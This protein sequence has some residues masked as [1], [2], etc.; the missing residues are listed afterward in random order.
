VSE[1][2][3]DAVGIPHVPRTNSLAGG[4]E[5]ASDDDDGFA[6]EDRARLRARL[7]AFSL[8]ERAV[9]GDGNC[10]ASCSCL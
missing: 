4:E 6:S 3:A 2:L 7:D 1:R 8:C 9:K 10:Q 5:W